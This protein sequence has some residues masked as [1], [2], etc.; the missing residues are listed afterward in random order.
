MRLPALL[1]R[2]STWVL[3]HYVNAHGVCWK[4]E[5]CRACCRVQAVGS[6]LLNFDRPEYL[7]SLNFGI[8]LI[9]YTDLSS[10]KLALIREVLELKD[11]RER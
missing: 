1:L 4:D 9:R 7:I 3:M 8:T 6:P 5:R 2:A 10:F 11:G